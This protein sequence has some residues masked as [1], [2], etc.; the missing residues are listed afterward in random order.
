MFT[1]FKYH[2]R[3]TL[4]APGFCFG[5]LEETALLKKGQNTGESLGREDLVQFSTC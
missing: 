2:V 1:Y 4:D 5:L 3:R